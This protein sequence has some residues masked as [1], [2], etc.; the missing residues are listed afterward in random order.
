MLWRLLTVLLL[1][2]LLLGMPIPSPHLLLWQLLLLLLHSKMLPKAPT[3][4]GSSITYTFPS[5]GM[6]GLCLT[7]TDANA[8]TSTVC[9]TLF[10]DSIGMLTPWPTFYDCLQIPNGPNMPGTPCQVFGTTLLGTWSANCQCIA[11][12]AV[13]CAGIPGGPNMPGTPCNDGDTL[14]MLDVW[15][16]NCQC[17]GVSENYYDC[18][19]ILKS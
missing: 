18:M 2:L 6:Y 3:T 7:I 16:P 1:L 14:T 8:C 12:S 9:D 5:P 15:T 4:T 13:D 19:Q 17:V 10:V 11:N